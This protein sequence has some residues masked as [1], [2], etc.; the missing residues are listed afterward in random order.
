[1]P[2]RTIPLVN[3]Q[4]Y[5]IYN[6]GAEK[7]PIFANK[8]DYQRILKLLAYYHLEGPKPKFSH[9]STTTHTIDPKKR[10]VEIIAFC[11][12]PNHFHLLIKQIKNHGVSEFMAKLSNSYTKFFNVKYDRIGALLQGQFK[13]TL[14]EDDEQFVHVLR[15]IHLNP[16][17]AYLV[18]NPDEYQWSSHKEYLD[19]AAGFCTKKEVLDFFPSLADYKQFILNQVDCAQTLELIKH[20]ILEDA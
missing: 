4:I 2:Y 6:R 15:Y 14:I 16:T 1:M 20:K 8:K 10:I 5:H 3:G 12:M 9:F 13:A 19:Q 17:S 18:E 7:K 11:L